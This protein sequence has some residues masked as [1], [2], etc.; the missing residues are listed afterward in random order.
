MNERSRLPGTPAPTRTFRNAQGMALAA[1]AWGPV[2]G[3]Q[4]LLLHGGGQNRH[5]WRG[6]GALL[7]NAGY[8]AVALDARGHG[9]SDWSPDGDYEQD[10]FVADLAAVVAALGERRPA[11]MGASLGGI[12]ALIAV[13]EGN[14][15]ASALVL[16]DIAPR[17]EQAGSARVK[18]FLETNT[19]GFASLDEVADAVAAYRP[20]TKR[21][22]T[23]G[24]AK[25]VRLGADGRYYWHWDPR[26]LEGRD[27]D[28]ATRYARLVPA[29]RALTIPA[30][31]VRGA[32]SDVVS[33]EAVQE[34]LA[35]CPHAEYLNVLDAGH[36]ITGD[37][38][39]RFG[40]ATLAFLAR[41]H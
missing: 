29:A 38:N 21:G 14:V 39:D 8:H 6:T 16:V 20:G 31:I 27:R 10:A 33:E 23:A 3:P 35:L 30:L 36:M 11:L 5:S 1:D 17:T 19:R 22:S 12:N 34:F 24:L 13:G 26:F 25:N 4:V 15:E 18:A 32:S 9:D 7:G 2:D 37:T 41:A 40:Q 28:I